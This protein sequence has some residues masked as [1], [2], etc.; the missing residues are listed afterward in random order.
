MRALSSAGNTEQADFTDWIS[1]QRS[2]CM[3]EIVPT[4]EAL[5]AKT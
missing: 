1:L 5:S 2:N 4:T 3:I